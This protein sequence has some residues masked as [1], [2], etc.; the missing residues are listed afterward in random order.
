MRDRDIHYLYLYLFRICGFSSSHIHD[1]QQVEALELY[2]ALVT[3]PAK[4]NSL[5]VSFF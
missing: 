3:I 1:S 4:V 2:G 5:E